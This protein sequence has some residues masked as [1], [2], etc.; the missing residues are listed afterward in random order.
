MAVS[1]HELLFLISYT[2]G[3]CV[4]IENTA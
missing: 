1:F 4:P 3:K 2:K